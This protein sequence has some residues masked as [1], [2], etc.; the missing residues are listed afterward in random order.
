MQ[1]GAI[2]REVLAHRMPPW[3]AVDG[4]GRFANANALTLRETRFVVS[5]VEGLGPRNKG[6]VFLNT[7]APAATQREV[8]ASVDFAAWRLGEPDH[9]VRV[10]GAASESKPSASTALRVQRA[11]VEPG[12]SGE[13]EKDAIAV[14]GREDVHPEDEPDPAHD[15]ED[16][17][18]EADGRVEPGELPADR[19][20]SGDGRLGE[21]PRGGDG[22][23]LRPGHAGR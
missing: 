17:E 7:L 6:E 20:Q 4:Y 12:D 21:E 11:I 8:K 10:A 1:R 9:I 23:P 5:W 16:H 15:R 3:P 13:L 2:H 18:D 22:P 19:R 14:Q